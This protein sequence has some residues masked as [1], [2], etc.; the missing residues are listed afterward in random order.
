MLGQP[1]SMLIRAWSASSSPV[2]PRRR[3]RDRPGAHDHRDA[4][5]SRRRGQVRRAL[6]Q[7]RPCGAGGE[8][9]HDRQ[10]VP[11]VRLD[12]HVFPVDEA[13]LARTSGS[14]GATTNRSLSS[15]PTP[16]SRACGTTRRGSRASPSA[17]S[18]TSST[19]V[20]SSPGPSGHRT[21][22]RSATRRR[23]S[24]RS[25]GTTSATA[26]TRRPT[27]RRS[28][29]TRRRSSPS[30]EPATRPPTPGTTTRPR[31]R[32]PVAEGRRAAEQS[33][34]RDPRGRF[35]LRDRPRCRRDR[36]DHLL[37]EHL[38]P[39]RHDRRRVGGQERCRERPHAQALGEHH[40]GAGVEGCDRLLRTRRPDAVPGE[41]RVQPGRLRMH[42]LHRQLGAAD[43]RGQ[44][45]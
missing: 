35:E 23:R 32:R 7:R 1:V 12:D 40:P 30:G 43:P 42:D 13:T 26:T 31:P 3:D 18:S 29:Q 41:A 22:S 34:G 2:A 20:P 38:E 5:P 21:G 15:R 37:H 8:P 39:V 11:G 19:V 27:A 24:A 4:A 45:R 17:S 36:G 28:G 33:R 44:R 9:R 16:R 10:H 14:P 6:R 25:S